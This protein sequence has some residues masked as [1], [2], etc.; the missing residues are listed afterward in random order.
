MT[1]RRITLPVPPRGILVLFNLLV[2]CVDILSLVL[3]STPLKI[4]GSAYWAC[5]LYWGSRY[6]WWG[7][8]PFTFTIGTDPEPEPRRLPAA[9][10]PAPDQCFI[11]GCYDPQRAATFGDATHPDC[12]DWLG[13]WKPPV[14][15]LGTTMSQFE[16][17][18]RAAQS[19]PAIIVPPTTTP[20][21]YILPARDK[22]FAYSWT[23]LCPVCFNHRDTMRST[24]NDHPVM[25]LCSSC[26]ALRVAK[27]QRGPHHRNCD[28]TVCYLNNLQEER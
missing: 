9:W 12:R 4:L 10:P 24:R 23:C 18:F 7:G 27:N 20:S 25:C 5:S 17:A 1:A 21:G 22:D 15:H 14:P 26:E 11:C 6:L 28:C 16:K 13:D 8:K 19:R 3:D 2:I